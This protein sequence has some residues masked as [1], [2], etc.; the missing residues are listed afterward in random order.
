M[1]AEEAAKAA[2]DKL[3]AAETAAKNAADQAKDRVRQLKTSIGLKGTIGPKVAPLVTH[4]GEGAFTLEEFLNRATEW[5][6]LELEDEEKAKSGARQPNTSSN[7]ELVKATSTAAPNQNLP[8]FL[9]KAAAWSGLNP[10]TYLESSEEKQPPKVHVKPTRNRRSR[11][12]DED[13]AKVSGEVRDGEGLQVE[14][15]KDAGA[16][17]EGRSGENAKEEGGSE[18]KNEAS[19]KEGL[20][21]HEV[22]E[23]DEEEPAAEE[24]KNEEVE[25]EVV[26]GEESEVVET[27]HEVAT[28][29]E[30]ENGG[31][32]VGEVNDGGSQDSEAKVEEPQVVEVNGGV[33]QVE[34]VNGGESQVDGGSK[35]E[36]ANDGGS[37]VEEANDGESQ[38]RETK[39]E[40]GDVEEKNDASKVEVKD[41][42]SPVVNGDNGELDNEKPV[43]DKGDNQCPEA[44]DGQG[45]EELCNN[46]KTDT[47]EGK[48]CENGGENG[49]ETGEE[50]PNSEVCGDNAKEITE[51]KKAAYSANE[52][53][54]N[55]NEATSV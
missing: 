23:R 38:E 21:E 40:G 13:T 34:E 10:D 27:S 32:Q 35:V 50:E 18:E 44:G 20:N 46:D 43:E 33:S 19:E 31:S 12:D 17:D 55:E 9:K 39:D 14:E 52:G 3:T 41:E 36:D 26:K 24:M 42:E 47:P 51:C 22:K 54:V 37:R 16:A 5:S 4:R 49:G 2:Q 11:A 25:E 8:E 30:V 48:K 45:K 7:D 6:G 15:G 29:E 1:K 28:P 53:E